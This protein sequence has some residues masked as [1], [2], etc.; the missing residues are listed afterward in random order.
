M[1]VLIV[2]FSLLLYSCGLIKHTID[3]IQF[4]K[5]QMHKHLIR[6]LEHGATIDTPKVD[7]TFKFPGVKVNWNLNARMER[8]TIINLLSI[9]SVRTRIVYRDGKIEYVE[10]GCPPIE[11]KESVPCPPQSED[12]KKPP[13]QHDGLRWWEVLILIIV[14]L[15]GAGVMKLFGR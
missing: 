8:D 3:P 5:D 9:D 10:T 4:H 7:Y 13:D 2:L 12:L 15:S 11:K 14:F 1:R 6:S